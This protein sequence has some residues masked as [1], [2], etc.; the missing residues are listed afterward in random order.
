MKFIHTADLHLASPFQGL[1][2]IPHQLWQRVH[3]ATFAA[4]KK[5]VTAAI[6]EDVDFMLIVG[7]VFDRE[8]KS[9]AAIDFFVA[10]LQRLAAAGIPVFLSYGNHDF[11]TGT[12]Q[13]ID[14]PAN[15]RVFF[16]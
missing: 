3:A 14:L 11:N 6:D 5:I 12:D 9:I 15:V 8:Q 4:F 2:D 16:L 13:Q 7:D 10:Q 1:T